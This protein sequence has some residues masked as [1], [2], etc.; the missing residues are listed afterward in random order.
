MYKHLEIPLRTHILGPKYYLN[1][2]N[3]HLQVSIVLIWI[4]PISSPNQTPLAELTKEKIEVL[5]V[6]ITERETL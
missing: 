4:C 5:D 2:H 1:V 6:I 3:A